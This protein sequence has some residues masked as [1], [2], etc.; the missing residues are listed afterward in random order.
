MHRVIDEE[1]VL[2]MIEGASPC[3]FPPDH[4]QAGRTRRGGNH[5]GPHR[6]WT[7]GEARDSSVPLFDTTLIHAKSVVEAA[8]NEES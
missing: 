7:A 4:R 1:M 8:I 5:P 3:Q 6:D 2:G